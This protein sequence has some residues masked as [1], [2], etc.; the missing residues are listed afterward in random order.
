MSSAFLWNSSAYKQRQYSKAGHWGFKYRE[1]HHSESPRPLSNRLVCTGTY[2]TVSLT[3]LSLCPSR[4]SPWVLAIN[5]PGRGRCCRAHSSLGITPTAFLHTGWRESTR[6]LPHFGW[7]TTPLPG[8][9]GPSVQ[10]QPVMPW[11]HLLFLCKKALQDLFHFYI[12][13]W[14]N[15]CMTALSLP[16]L[17]VLISSHVWIW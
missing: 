13:F 8:L 3:W 4:H 11:I 12:W 16:L 5:Q 15:R 2:C 7:T 9:V 17:F 6:T 14:N 1:F 10:T